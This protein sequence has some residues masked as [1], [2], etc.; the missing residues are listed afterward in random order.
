M[1]S[2]KSKMVAIFATNPGSGVKSIAMFAMLAGT[3]ISGATFSQLF[4]IKPIRMVVPLSPGP[5]PDEVAR[6]IARSMTDSIGQPVV[7]ENRPG[8]TG[9]IGAD[10]VAKSAADGYTIVLATSSTHVTAKFLVKNLPYDPVKDFTPITAAVEPVTCI[11]LHP[12][13]PA[14]TVREFIDYA[15]SNPGKLAYGSPGVGSVFHLIGESLNML[16]GLDM[17]HIPYK[18]VVPAMSDLVAGQ[19]P[20]T[21]ISA[22]NAIPFMRVGKARI[23]AVLESSRYS[24]LPEI[25]TVGET[26]S[27]FVKPP[28]WFG[29]FGPAGLPPQVTARLNSEIVKA[30]NSRKLRAPFDERLLS[31]IAVHAAC[32]KRQIAS[33]VRNA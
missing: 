22:A 11:A 12:S 19:I 31:V 17:V 21:F 6:L 14:N 13:V 4:P 9:I 23:I 15:K 25:P 16:I 24:R 10:Y 29:F 3:L 28:S 7:V 20:V 1:N 33:T 18:G 2:I 8:A 27:G 26:L 5:G 32:V 30:V